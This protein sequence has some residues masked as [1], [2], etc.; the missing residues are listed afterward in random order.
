MNCRPNQLNYCGHGFDGIVSA[1]LCIYRRQI[2]EFI[3]V[4]VE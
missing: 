4:G 1:A 3:Q 2:L